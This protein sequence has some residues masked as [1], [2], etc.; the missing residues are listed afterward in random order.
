MAFA[1]QLLKLRVQ[2]DKLQLSEQT[3]GEF[4]FFP[5]QV[6][7]QSPFKDFTTRKLYFS[8]EETYTVEIPQWLSSL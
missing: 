8:E 4:H 6:S 1:S 2:V 3:T 7:F 5:M